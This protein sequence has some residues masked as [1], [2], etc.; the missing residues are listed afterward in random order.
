MQLLTSTHRA[1]NSTARP[2]LAVI[3]HP[4]ADARRSDSDIGK[5]EIT[6]IRTK[7]QIPWS[8]GDIQRRERLENMCTEVQQK[9]LTLVTAPPGCGKSTLARQWAETSVRQDMRVAWFSIDAD[10]NDPN[11]FLPYLHH[12]VV[13]SGLGDRTAHSNASRCDPGRTPSEIASLLINWVAEAGEELLIVLDN[14][15]WITDVNIHGHLSYILA[16]AP[17]NLHVVVLASDLPALPIGR[18][19]ARNQLLELNSGAI[20]FTKAETLELFRKNSLLPIPFLQLEEL[21]RFTQGWAAA[22]RIISLT[23]GS[24]GNSPSLVR[25]IVDCRIFDAI[26]QYLD[27]LF[28]NFPQGL[29]DMMVDTAIVE[30]LSLPLCLALSDEENAETFFSQIRQ[31][32]ILI[33][34][35]PE[36]G[37]Y[38]YPAPVR[39]YLHK[40]LFRKGNRY[41]AALHRKAYAWYAEN[42]QWDNAVDHALAVGDT[43]IA[44]DW[45]ESHAMPI[46]KSGKF[47]T[48]LKWRQKIATL[49]VR[50]P[51]SVTLSFAWAQAVSQSPD[52]ALDLLAQIAVSPDHL[53]PAVQA[54]YHAIRAVAL[55]LAD[56]IEHAAQAVAHCAK[57]H[58]TDRWISGIVANV[59]LY[60][61]LQNGHWTAFFSESSVLHDPTEGEANTHVLRL[62]LL[63]IA[64]LL[65]GQPAL[66]ERY[67]VEALQLA[68]ATKDKDSFCFSA[69]PSGLL[70]ALHYEQGRL[71]ELETLLASRLESIAA[72]GYLDCTLAAFVAA[73]RSATTKGHLSEALATLEKAESIAIARKWPRLEAAVLLERICLFL[74]DGRQEEAEGCLQRLAQLSQDTGN[75]QTS[76]ICSAAQMHQ[77]G[78][79]HL[80]IHAGRA[81]QAIAPLTALQHQF[82]K[83]GNELYAVRMGTLLAIA[84]VKLNRATQAE[85]I[86][87]ETL[88]R[89]EKGGFVRSV[90]D[91]GRE[92][93]KLLSGLCA[94][95]GDN[96]AH[97]RLR[98]HCERTLAARIDVPGAPL[99][100]CG[101]PLAKENAGIP[102][103]PK[104][105]DIL[106]LIARGQSNKEV[107]RN[108]KVAPETIKTH[109]KNIFLKL[110]V[111]RRIQAVAKAQALGLVAR[112][113]LLHKSP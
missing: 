37:R 7:I 91:Q 60:C 79:A 110:S 58:L 40:R 83:N 76:P 17:S 6:F 36:L 65:R 84:N 61:S 12:A 71:D 5:P 47:G 106:A 63:G 97:A 113:A 72:S 33:P 94:S 104:E 21:Y 19:R 39:R 87:R 29:I 44:V 54:Q 70:A 105:R 96:E 56:R 75:A 99:E 69:W 49:S 50:V 27:D 51:Q 11:R 10:D 82:S 34:S 74:E 93:G 101:S 15:S 86:F 73:A 57:E 52:D 1:P 53:S 59:E 2:R 80:A 55:V 66:A 38:T 16:N 62:T 90:L 102:L 98:Q 30:T 100:R 45:M 85:R 43:A 28:V 68:P 103:T 109:L 88:E 23:M 42:A 4:S 46:L 108:L 112:E 14:Y 92:T 89:A 35:Q 32:Q 95:L 3:E 64:A 22:V 67:A 25:G 77:I 8:H 48:L 41:L 81:E 111:E 107:A 13:H 26:D 31:Q 9:L 24:L 20:R 78:K 18:L